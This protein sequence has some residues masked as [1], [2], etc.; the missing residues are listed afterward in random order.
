VL[1]SI[2]KNKPW[3]VKKDM[4]RKLRLLLNIFIKKEDAELIE[5]V[6]LLIDNDDM[7]AILKNDYLTEIIEELEIDVDNKKCLSAENINDI[8]DNFLEDY[9]L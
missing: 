1:L 7:E 5:V 3:R 2:Y 9:A 4:M 6:N 8:A